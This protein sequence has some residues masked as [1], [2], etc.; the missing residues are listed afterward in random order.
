MTDEKKREIID[1]AKDIR[2]NWGNDAISIAERLGINV[3]FR[4]GREIDAHIIK[5]NQYPPMI[6]LSGCDDPIGQ[7]VLCAHELGHALLHDTGINW[8]EGSN[9][10][11][12]NDVE[13][14][15]NLFAVALLFDE[16]DF[17]MPLMDMSNYALKSVLDYNI[18]KK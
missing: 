17:N 4:P 14:E 7:V 16:R 1:F 10:T 11:I 9:T 2:A 15:A 5:V 13:Y 6:S 18:R 3:L 8:F 12:M